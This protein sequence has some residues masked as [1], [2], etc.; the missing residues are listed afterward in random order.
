MHQES[1]DSLSSRANDSDGSWSSAERRNIL[2]DSLK[3]RDA[4]AFTKSKLFMFVFCYVAFFYIIITD[5]K[6]GKTGYKKL[7]SSTANFKKT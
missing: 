7:A 5:F 1:S 3:E 4:F 2:P 6:Y